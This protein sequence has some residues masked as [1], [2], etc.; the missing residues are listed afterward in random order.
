MSVYKCFDWQSYLW[1][2]FWRQSETLHHALLLSGPEGIGKGRF[3]TAVAARLLCERRESHSACGE[4]DACRWFAAGNHPDYRKVSL[5]T[6][7]GG[8]DGAGAEPPKGAKKAP[9]TQIR[10]DQ[11]RALEDFVFVGSHRQGRRVVLIDPADALNP[12]AANSLLKMLEEPPPSVYFLL[13]T[14]KIKSLLP[15]LRSRCRKIVFPLPETAEAT[16]WLS[17]Q[18]VADAERALRFSAGAPLKALGHDQEKGARDSVDQVFAALV[19][20]PSDPIALAAQWD[21]LLRGS[22]SLNAEQLVDALQKWL[23]DV[24]RCRHG[25][26]PRYLPT[27]AKELGRVA[28]ASSSV[29]LLRFHRDL[30]KIRATARHPLNPQLFLEDVAARYSQ[31]TAAGR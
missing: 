4:C 16:R 19:R 10:I 29:R 8:E 5:E 31:A 13:I 25:A 21:S 15:T 1:K 17:E 23:Y 7:D 24:I 6:V 12:A 26:A 3:A 30:M 14:S 28:T 27:F 9:P 11:I 20:S 22:T 18:G 2:N